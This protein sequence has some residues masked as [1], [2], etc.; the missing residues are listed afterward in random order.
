[1]LTVPACLYPVPPGFKK[2]QPGTKAKFGNGKHTLPHPTVRQ[3][4]AV[5][6]HMATLFKAAV[7]R[8]EVIA[9]LFGKRRT[10][11]IPGYCVEL[12][13]GYLRGSVLRVND[14]QFSLA[15]SN[16]ES[17]DNRRPMSFRNFQETDN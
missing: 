2:I 4:I 10:G 13:A 3:T 17:H 15:K 11:S 7:C 14:R 16:T 1:M 6:K 12:P 5:Q 8:K 9:E